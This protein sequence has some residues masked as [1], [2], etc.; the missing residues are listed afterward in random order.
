MH[1]LYTRVFQKIKVKGVARIEVLVFYGLALK[2]TILTD[3]I[4]CKIDILM[5]T[6]SKGR[7]V[8]FKAV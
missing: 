1:K 3:Q 4:H 8:V 7:G 2:I 6:A 5:S